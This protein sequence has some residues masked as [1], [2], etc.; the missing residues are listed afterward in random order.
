MP[1][2]LSEQ[3][4]E[5]GGRGKAAGGERA[6][7][8]WSCGQMSVFSRGHEARCQTMLPWGEIPRPQMSTE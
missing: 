3:E 8:P 7:Y 2:L 6:L 5:G 1:S 4:A